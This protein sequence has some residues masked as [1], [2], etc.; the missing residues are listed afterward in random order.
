MADEKNITLEQFKDFA[1]K[2]DARLDNLET[3]KADKPE[4]LNITI[5]ASNWTEN[6]D[7]AT[8]A[9]GYAFSCDVAVEGATSADS[10]DTIIAPG[11]MQAAVACGLCPTSTV[12]DGAVRYYAVSAPTQA[13]SVQVRMIKMKGV[14]VW[15][16]L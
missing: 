14:E 5:P 1:Q 3:G 10:A 9:A 15:T 2:A 16:D 4:M 6:Q 11:S 13:L 7:E 8:S 12:V